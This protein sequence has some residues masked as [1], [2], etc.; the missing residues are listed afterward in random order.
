MKKVILVSIDGM[1]PDG[2]AGCGNPF[3]E[4]LKKIGSWTL[5]ARTVFPSVTLP[6]HMSLF[7]SVPP[8]RHGITT[9]L[10]MP[11]V[12]PIS[13]LFEQIKN[14]GGKATMYFGWNPLRDVARPAS[15]LAAEY[16]N[17]YSEEHTDGILTDRMIDYTEKMKPDFVFLYMVETDEKGGHDSGWMSGTYLDYISHAIG[18]VKRVLEKFGDEYTVIVTADHGGHDRAHGT[19]MPEDMTIPMFFVGEDF[20]AGKELTGVSL[21]DLAPTIAAVM[22][23]AKAPE[24]EGKNLVG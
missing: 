9:N 12:R 8:E 7:H 15:L 19:D 17:A 6:C 14:A 21:L 24:W 11:P 4:E 3:V 22:G 20:E 1:R 23:V 18:N 16:L 2:V 5:N 13:G 10:Y